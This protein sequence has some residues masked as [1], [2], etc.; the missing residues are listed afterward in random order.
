MVTEI[1]LERA[2]MGMFVVL[3]LGM[4]IDI[5][6]ARRASSG[7][8]AQK[9]I[10]RLVIRAPDDFHTHLRFGA[11][12]QL[13]LPYTASVFARFLVM[14]NAPAIRNAINVAAYRGAILRRSG[15][16]SEP[17]MTIKIDGETTVETIAAA[18]G[19]GAIAGKVY[20]DGVTTGSEGGV[21]NF[22]VLWPILREMERL[23]MALCLHA[24]MPGAYVIRREIE[25]LVTVGEIL[26]AFPRLRVVIEHITT[27][28]TIAFVRARRKHG[29]KIAA[30]ITAHHLLRT[31]NDAI[32]SKVRVHEHC[33]PCAKGPED[34][35]ALI[36]AATSGDPGFFFGSDTAPHAQSLKECAEGCAGVFTAPV[37]LP[38][39]VEIFERADKLDRL[40]D[41]VSR[42]GAE[43]YG[44]PLNV[45]TIV[46]EKRSWRVPRI[47]R[48]FF[49]W[50]RVVPWRAGEL[51]TWQVT[52]GTKRRKS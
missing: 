2:T 34:R 3:F 35:D 25:C 28:E 26:D 17:L 20:P 13:V 49:G 48:S 21:R 14:P 27:K 36:E 44:L 29:K 30:T 8:S 32:G 7:A 10:R 9:A 46:L 24:E 5:L 1:G 51:V 18:Q 39:L 33:Q 43:F 47:V 22:R 31:L 40:E 45:G 4:A 15:W 41:F 19:S 11:M 42:F 6:M 50:T 37:A 38:T 12:L 23:D 52:Q 16:I